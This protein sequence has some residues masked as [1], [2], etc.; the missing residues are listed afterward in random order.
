MTNNSRNSTLCP[1]CRR[2]ISKDEA[3]CPYC[4]L[5][6]PG[7]WWKNNPFTRGFSDPYLF[8]NAVIY[9]NVGMYLL[10][11]LIDTGGI[12]DRF[13]SLSFL[14]PSNT[15]L[16]VMG[17]TGT[18]PI[19]DNHK[20]FLTFLSANYLHGSIFHIFMNMM[21]LRQLAPLVVKEFGIYRMFVIYTVSGVIGFAVSYLAGVFLTI[22][23]SAAVFGLI[24][25]AIYFGKSRGGLYGD[26]IY[27]QIGGWALGFLVIGFLV[28][29]INNWGHGGGL[30]GGALVAVLMGYSERKPETFT[31]KVIAAACVLVTALTLLWAALSGLVAKLG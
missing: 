26:A 23:A 16:V 3:R 7:H 28:P 25:A 12:G 8:I 24:G 20:S 19:D 22:G 10:S 6:R 14:S 13:T 15:S 11:L 2:L 4:G 29:G 17:A 21:A 1:N 27:K 31:H 5:N 9:V 30:V 18:L